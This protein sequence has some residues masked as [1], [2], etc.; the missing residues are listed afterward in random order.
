MKIF[1]FAFYFLV[2]LIKVNS[3]VATVPTAPPPTSS[4][5]PPPTVPTVPP[6]TVPT[7]GSTS[8]V[9]TTTPQIPVFCP[10]TGIHHLPTENCQDFIICVYGRDHLGTCAEGF[11]FDLTT[12]SCLTADKVDCGERN[13]P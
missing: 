4:S 9:S 5:V 12:N 3:Q 10:P 13:R 6:P 1:Y 7:V 2:I 8:L 11:L